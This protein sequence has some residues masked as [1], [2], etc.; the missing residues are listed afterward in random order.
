MDQL[1]SGGG[2]HCRAVHYE[3]KGD[4][5]NNRHSNNSLPTT[6]VTVSRTLLKKGRPQQGKVNSGVKSKVRQ[7][8][9]PTMGM[10]LLKWPQGLTR[11]Y[12]TT[13]EPKGVGT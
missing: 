11:I 9:K 12:R 13:L 8:W 7:E 4:I 3:T 2:S 1:T 6:L 10:C 5:T